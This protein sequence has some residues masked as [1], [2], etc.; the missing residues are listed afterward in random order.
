M[1]LHHTEQRYF[2]IDNTLQNPWLS[3]NHVRLKKCD[4]VL[5]L[6]T[7]LLLLSKSAL[8]SRALDQVPPTHVPFFCFQK[9]YKDRNDLFSKHFSFIKMFSREKKK[10][11]RHLTYPSSLCERLTQKFKAIKIHSSHLLVISTSITLCTKLIF[12]IWAKN[13]A[14]IW[15]S[16]G[17]APFHLLRQPFQGSQ[18][19]F[20]SREPITVFADRIED[21]VE[22]GEK[23]KGRH[24]SMICFQ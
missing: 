18:F 5:F 8:S 9:F 20:F 4:P 15:S 21:R 2:L 13:K 14:H 24:E 22:E 7:S 6:F 23:K 16:K 19:P 1:E 12:S 10:K 11:K 3:H 17:E